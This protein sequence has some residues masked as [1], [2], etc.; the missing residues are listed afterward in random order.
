MKN[1]SSLNWPT[2]KFTHTEL[3]NLNGKK[4]QTVWNR[5]LWARRIGF[6]VAAGKR[7]GALLWKLNP[8]FTLA[9]IRYTPS[10]M[11]HA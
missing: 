4:N 1:L 7:K 11:V 8:N 2:E 6:I 9:L 3:A 5:Y 10:P